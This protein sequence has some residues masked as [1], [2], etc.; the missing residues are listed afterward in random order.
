MTLK[1]FLRGHIIRPT[2]L[3]RGYEI[4]HV[5]RAKANNIQHQVGWPNYKRQHPS[6][7]SLSAFRRQKT[8]TASQN[9][10]T[11]YTNIQWGEKKR[12]LKIVFDI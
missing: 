2:N 12:S 8:L 11:L 10:L 5:F 3:R 1:H 7:K 9:T 6:H 4:I